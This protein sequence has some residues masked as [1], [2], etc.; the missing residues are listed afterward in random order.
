MSFKESKGLIYELQYDIIYI[1]NVVNKSSGFD[2]LTH[3]K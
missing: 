3:R 2:C 1:V